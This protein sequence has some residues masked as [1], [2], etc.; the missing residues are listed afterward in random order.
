MC[1]MCLLG[2]VVIVVAV[3]FP[4]SIVRVRGVRVFVIEGFV[5]RGG[6]GVLCILYRRRP[7]VSMSFSISLVGTRSGVQT[8]F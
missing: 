1:C 4:K 8:N 6:V 7:S 2:P 3:G 5:L